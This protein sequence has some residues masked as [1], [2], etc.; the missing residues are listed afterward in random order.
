MKENTKL[1]WLANKQLLAL[2]TTFFVSNKDYKTSHA[3]L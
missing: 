3:D 1:R 2:L